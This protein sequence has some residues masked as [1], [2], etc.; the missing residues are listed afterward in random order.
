MGSWSPR[1]RKPRP[2]PG[3]LAGGGLGWFPGVLGYLGPTSPLSHAPA[4]P[5]PSLAILTFAVGSSTV[6]QTGRED[7]G[8]IRVLSAWGGW[9]ELG[10]GTLNPV[11]LTSPQNPHT[12]KFPHPRSQ[13][14]P[15]TWCLF[16]SRPERMGW[17]VGPGFRRSSSVVGSLSY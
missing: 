14:P 6:V 15:R 13:P 11:H 2:T 8:S 17:E 7:W 9:A 5:F 16:V 1:R 10:P 4:P 3:A 12:H